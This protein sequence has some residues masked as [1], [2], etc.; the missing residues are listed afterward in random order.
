[1]PHTITE[2]FESWQGKFGQH[3]NVDVW[4]IVPHCL[5]WCIGVKEMLEALRVAN[6]L[7]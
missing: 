2:L 1:M 3:H 5:I 7:C 4:R 6:V